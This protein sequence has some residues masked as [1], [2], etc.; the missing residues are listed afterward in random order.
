MPK[1]V[2]RANINDVVNIM[3]L[4]S[5]VT[6]LHSDNRED[7]FRNPTLHYSE[8]EIK[9]FIANDG[10]NIFVATSE[11]DEITGVLL[12][13]IRVEHNHCVLLDSKTLWIEDTCVNQSYRKKGYGKMLLDFAKKFA[14]D[15]GCSRMELNVWS[16]NKNAH[17]FYANQGMNEQRHVM[18]Y[19]FELTDKGV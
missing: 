17:D 11:T 18:E 3:P 10:L 5:S 9:S 6:Q 16:F 2:R 13:K 7:I 8:S 14:E 19:I 15:S 1:E 12:C 4:L